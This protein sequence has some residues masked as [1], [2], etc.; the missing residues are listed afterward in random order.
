MPLSSLLL[1]TGAGA[2]HD[3]AVGNEQFPLMPDWSNDLINRLSLIGPG[4]AA[5]LGLRPGLSGELFE[6]CLGDFLSWRRTLAT[7]GAHIGMGADLVGNQVPSQVPDWFRNAE[8]HALSVMRVLY[9]S[10]YALFPY[11]RVSTVSVER[12]YG[13]LLNRLGVVPDTPVVCATTNYDVCLEAALFALGRSP[14]WGEDALFPSGRRLVRPSGLARRATAGKTPVIHLHGRVGWYRDE[15]DDVVSY[16]AT[17]PYS[18]TFGPPALLLPD[19]RKDYAEQR[20][21]QGLWSELDSALT[22]V[23]RVLV[24]G[25]SLQD[26][27]LVHRLN[28]AG[29]TATKIGITTLPDPEASAAPLMPVPSELQRLSVLVPSSQVIPLEFGPELRFNEEDINNWLT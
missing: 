15:N 12:A 21:V 9:E 1:I 24:L 10:L 14:D 13:G 11:E 5:E 18:E 22:Q 8:M 17:G 20:V 23:E 6:Q 29:A 25:H 2:S 16:D 28:T 27:E 19:P 3:L 4:L 26:G 7:T